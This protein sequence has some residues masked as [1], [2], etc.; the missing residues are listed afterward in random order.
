MEKTPASDRKGDPWLLLQ[1][2]VLTP[3]ETQ[4]VSGELNPQPLP[5]V[6]RSMLKIVPSLVTDTAIAVSVTGSRS[7]RG[8]PHNV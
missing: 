8:D 3:N 1:P 4:Q 5:P 2:I 7:L 6:E